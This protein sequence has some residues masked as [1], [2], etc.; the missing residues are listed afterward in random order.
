[1]YKAEA[2][3]SG[4]YGRKVKTNKCEPYSRRST[5][6]VSLQ[7]QLKYMFVNVHYAIGKISVQYNTVFSV[8]WIIID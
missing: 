7:E 3:L 4:S 2:Y 5:K 8:I 1:M 6:K